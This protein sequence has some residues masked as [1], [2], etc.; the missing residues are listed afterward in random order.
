MVNFSKLLEKFLS[1]HN[2]DSNALDRQRDFNGGLF[3]WE[4]MFRDRK[5]GAAACGT[6]ELHRSLPFQAG[7]D[8]SDLLKQPRA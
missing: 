4:E 5:S 8:R 1:R 6:S 7:G 2:N 3:S